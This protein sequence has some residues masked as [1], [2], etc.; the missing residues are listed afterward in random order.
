MLTYGRSR[1]AVS[2]N[3]YWSSK[4]REAASRSLLWTSNE[5]NELPEVS[6]EFPLKLIG[7]STN[8]LFNRSI[9]AR[10]QILV[11]SWRRRTRIYSLDRKRTY[12]EVFTLVSSVRKAS[13][14]DARFFCQEGYVNWGTQRNSYLNSSIFLVWTERPSSQTVRNAVT[15]NPLIQI[16][17]SLSS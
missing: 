8:G 3:L 10:T 11:H 5:V 7:Q 4:L 13:L 1:W 15:S 6:V 12:Q 14:T 16:L 9:M 2:R 17:P